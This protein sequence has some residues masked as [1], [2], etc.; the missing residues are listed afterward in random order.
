MGGVR[1][2]LWVCMALLLTQVLVWAGLLEPWFQT[3]IQ[4]YLSDCVYPLRGKATQG[5]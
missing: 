3:R 5:A 2:W 4:V 1:V